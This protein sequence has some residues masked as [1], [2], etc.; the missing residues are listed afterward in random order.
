M[1]YPIGLYPLFLVTLLAIYWAAPALTRRH[2]LW[3]GSLALLTFLS[4]RATTA[5]LLLAGTIYALGRQIGRAGTP[6]RVRTTR[7]ALGIAIPV[8]YLCTF[9][10]LPEYS[11]PI[12]S[13]LRLMTSGELLLP[14]G[15]S[16]FTFKF[17][18]YI[19]ES[20]RGTLPAHDWWDFLTYSSL[21]SIFAAGPIERFT[22]LQPQLKAPA[23]DRTE[24]AYGLQRIFFGT[25]KKVVLADLVVLALLDQVR[26]AERS[27]QTA[28]LLAQTIYLWGRF[29]YIYFDFS[30]YSDIAIGT[31]RLFG[32]KV[33]ENFEWP[34][35]RKN[36]SEFWRAWHISLS[37]WCRDYV[38]FPVLGSTRNP[39]LAVYASML[40]LGYW[41]GANP[42]WI[43]WGAWH[44]SGL[45]IWQQWQI[46]KRRRPALQRVSRQN[47]LY[48]VTATV[49]T[50]N[51]VALGAVWQSSRSVGEALRYLYYMV[52][53]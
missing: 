35:L 13:L 40:V 16:Y 17:L 33:I 47:T 18:H 5:F 43:C 1:L 31:S 50:L 29:L 11:P 3:I 53:P 7:L 37:S 4:W 52:T 15:I 48:R 42:T 41:H 14:L 30:G 21:F 23:F 20:R 34:I 6:N 25:L 38:Y 27:P 9:K 2:V 22:G 51:F 26:V 46:L 36:I 19:I 32:L 8:L 39:K 45:A 24:F 49:L 12:R 28:S 10:Y 44:A